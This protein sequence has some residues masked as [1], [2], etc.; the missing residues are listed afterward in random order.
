MHVIAAEILAAPQGTILHPSVYLVFDEYCHVLL[1]SKELANR[2]E[3]ESWRSSL[4]ADEFWIDRDVVNIEEPGAI[5][6]LVCGNTGVG[7]ST[8]INEV[9]GAEVVSCE[10]Y[11]TTYHNSYMKL[12]RQSRRGSEETT[13]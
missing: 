5:R 3:I 10:R 11:P 4:C 1:D 9:F 6:V 7:K 2:K 12:R 13:T 8:L